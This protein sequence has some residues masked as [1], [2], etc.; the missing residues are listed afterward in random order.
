MAIPKQVEELE[1]ALGKLTKYT[2]SD[3]VSR[4]KWGEIT[5]ENSR[6][7]INLVLSIANDLQSMPLKLLTTTA[8]EAILRAIPSVEEQ[9][10]NIDH[11]TTTSGDVSSNKNNIVHN[12]RQ[13][14]EELHIEASPWI[15]YLAYRRGD[16]AEN[17]EQLN[18]AISDAK[19]ALDNAKTWITNK[20][21]DID[22]IAK[23]ARDAAARAGVATFTEEF[24]SEANTLDTRSKGWLKATGWF[25]AWTIAAAVLFYFGAEVGQNA[26]GWDTL[27]NIVSKVTIFA[28]LFSG[29]VWCGRI[30][31][32]LIHQATVNRHR[33]LSL[34]TFQAFVEATDDP[35]VK[36]AVL[37]TA[38]KTVF[39]NVPT[40]LV[41]PS[42]G[43]PEGG[44]Q[45]VEFGKGPAEKVSKSAAEEKESAPQ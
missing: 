7:D 3:L 45:F 41:E 8:S 42:G 35:H 38:T 32:A 11:F 16:I 14:A 28:V 4:P 43:N 27:S 20:K 17:I 34:K 29:T 44:V 2:E 33:A 24:N 12:L 31:R 18:G 23:A 21:D 1:E 30:Y 15:P 19:I 36:D 26:D 39:A 40:G 5:F 10:R 6:E 25:A 13:A 37:V 22:K 9:L